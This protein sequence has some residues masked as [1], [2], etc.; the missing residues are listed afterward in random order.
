MK[1]KEK[2]LLLFGLL[3]ITAFVLWTLAVLTVD[4]KP[5]GL[6][7]T[8]IGFAS[9]NCSFH[10]LT[11]VHMTLY[12][13]TD[14]LSLIPA[15][16]CI[17]FC[18]IGIMQWVKR[19]SITRVDLDI[20]ILGI[21]YSA[22]ISG[23]LL[24]ETLPV[25]YRPVLING[26]MEASYPS[27]TTLLVLSVM[28]ACIFQIN[29]RVQSRPARTT[30][31]TLC[32]IFSILMVAGRLLSGVHWLTDIAGAVLLSSGIFLIYKGSVLMS[33]RKTRRP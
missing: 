3:C 8:D 1:S 19:R 27:S 2:R 23:Y 7:G 28:S 18:I 4:V 15:G 29:R 25:N 11:G 24:F 13:V 20:I 16:I 22:V 31:S 33:D 14:W 26:I 10:Q 9:L 5:A 21:Y 17:M 6:K 12:T 32:V 30:L